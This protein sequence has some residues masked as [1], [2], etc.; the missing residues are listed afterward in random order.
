[1]KKNQYN[2]STEVDQ[3]SS[4]LLRAGTPILNKYIKTLINNTIESS[5][6]PIRLKEAQVV[7]LHKKNDPLHKKLWTREHYTYNF[8]SI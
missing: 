7:S 8:K 1:M 5:E 2:I 6:F 3:I 4:K